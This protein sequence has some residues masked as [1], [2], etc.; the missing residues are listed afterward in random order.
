[1]SILLYDGCAITLWSY[2]GRSS[3]QAAT[4]ALMRYNRPHNMKKIAIVHDWFVTFAGAEKVVQQLL[5]IFPQAELFSLIDFLSKKD[6]ALLGN[7]AIRT[8]FLQNAP[9][10]KKYYRLYLALMPLAI[11]QIDVSGYDLILSNSH[12]V[13]KAVIGGP[14]QLHISYIHT[15]IRY[16]WDLQGEYLR[17]GGLGKLKEIA[18]RLL[19]HYIRTWD[20]ASAGRPDLLIANSKFVARRIQKTYRRDAHVIYPPVDTDYFTP[21]E[22]QREDFFLA[23]SR[24]VPY[25]RIDLIAEAF[26]S[27]PE[28]KLVIIG[29]G[30]EAAKLERLRGPNITWLGYQPDEVLRDNMRR[31]RAFIFAA[32]EDFGIIPLEA[33]ACGAPVIAYGAGGVRETV[34][35][36]G[37]TLPPTGIHYPEQSVAAIRAA[38]EAFDRDLGQFSPE[39]CRRNA[40]RFSNRRF[41]EEFHAFTLSA[42]NDFTSKVNS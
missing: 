24:L 21:S 32:R 28:K 10:A 3:G 7:A 40:E 41:R 9:F 25:K 33:Q 23:A 16:A 27:M 12:A 13:S 19:L 34:C 37:G 20:A 22:E 11:E 6:R 35:A 15:P 18:A 30:P 39:A 36:S 29:D 17:A 5:Q 1:V 38:V 26:Q 2:F 42:W 31:C 8:S 4:L 14:D